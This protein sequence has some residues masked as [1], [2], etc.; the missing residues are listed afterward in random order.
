[1]NRKT[2]KKDEG[3][4]AFLAMLDSTP[5]LWSDDRVDTVK[6]EAFI[7]WCFDTGNLIDFELF[8][9]LEREQFIRSKSNIT[10]YYE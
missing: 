6:Q 9:L 7:R 4:K 10:E 2:R 8:T 5:M 3:P 1:M